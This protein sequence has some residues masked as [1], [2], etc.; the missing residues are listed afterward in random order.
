MN[1]NPWVGSNSSPERTR[2]PLFQDVALF[3]Q[4]RFSRC[5]RPQ[6]EIALGGEVRPS[7][8]RPS[9]RS[10]CTAIANRLRRRLELR[11]EALPGCRP[12]RTSSTIRR[13]NSGV[14]GGFDL[15]IVDSSFPEEDL[16]STKPTALQG[17]PLGFGLSDRRPSLGS[18]AHGR[19]VHIASRARGSPGDRGSGGDLVGGAERHGSRRRKRVHGGR[20]FHRGALSRDRSDQRR[21]EPDDH[22]GGLRAGLERLP[23]P[24]RRDG[25]Q[26]PVMTGFRQR[27]GGFDGVLRHGRESRPPRSRDRRRARRVHAGRRGLRPAGDRGTRHAGASGGRTSRPARP[28]GGGKQTSPGP[29]AGAAEPRPSRRRVE[30]AP[31]DADSPRR[32]RGRGSRCDGSPAAACALHLRGRRAARVPLHRFETVADRLLLGRSAL[33]LSAGCPSLAI[34]SPPASAVASRHA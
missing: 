2:P 11:R 31:A 12:A 33:R 8:R 6:L 1:S 32:G 3:A 9:S 5:R 29:I 34:A 20:E 25:G 22:G 26:L 23:A 28:A 24:R 16:V 18:D 27:C 15:G 30:A 13:R 7:A 14:Y 21:L 10:A 4:R 19:C 17:L